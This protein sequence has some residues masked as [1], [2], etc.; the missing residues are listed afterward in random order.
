MAVI[1][2][3]L[4]SVAVLVIIL[5]VLAALA[6]KSRGKEHKPD[7]YTFFIMGI[8]WS[9]AGIP[10]AT[11]T[12]NYG[13]FAIGLVFLAI[14]L[15]NRDK[16]ETNRKTWRDMENTERKIM[17]WVMVIMGLLVL[18]GLVFFFLLEKGFI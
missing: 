2:W 11:T 17:T 15:A 3:I 1:L 10:L 5:A 12:G 14:G 18:V 8:V 6:L 9:G 4:I 7:Y 16:W 13:F